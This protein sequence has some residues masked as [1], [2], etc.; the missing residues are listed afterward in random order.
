MQ[1][2]LSSFEMFVANDSM[3]D[4]VVGGRRLVPPPRFG[5]ANNGST[6]RYGYSNGSAVLARDAAQETKALKQELSQASADLQTRNRE[7]AQVQVAARCVLRSWCVGWPGVP[8]QLPCMSTVGGT[9]TSCSLRSKHGHI[10]NP[11]LKWMRVRHC[12]LVCTVL[13]SCRFFRF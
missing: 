12:S 11:I 1:D 8:T 6:D 3:G 13:C 9:C 10:W 7:L 5:N 2:P 4:E